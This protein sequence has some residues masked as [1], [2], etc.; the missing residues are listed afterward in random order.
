MPDR[1]HTSILLVPIPEKQIQTMCGS[2]VKGSQKSTKEIKG[3][4]SLLS[5]GQVGLFNWQGNVLQ[6]DTTAVF[7]P[8]HS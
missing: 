3:T 6:A 7:K 4:E 8:Q 5:K 1:A 2:T